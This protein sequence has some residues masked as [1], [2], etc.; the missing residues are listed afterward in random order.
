MEKVWDVVVLG[1]GPA[2]VMSALKLAMSGKKVCMVEQGPQRLGG[3]CLHEGCMATKS[4]LKTAEVYQTIKQAEEYGIEATA[5]PLDLHCTVM[6]KNDHLKTLNNRLQQMALQSGLHI[7]PGHGSFVS[8]TRIAVDGPDG[9]VELQAEKIVIA[10]G[11]R[12]R[13]LDEIP[14]DGALIL[15]S[16]QMLQQTRLPERLLIIGGG[17]IG[18]EFASMFQAFGSDV[19]LIESAEHL[20]PREDRDTGETLQTCLEQ[21]DIRVL[22]GK[23]I[24]RV[25]KTDTQVELVLQGND[26]PLVADQMLVA[27]GRKP[28]TDWLDLAAAEI[29]CDGETI[30]VNDQLQT[31]QP[32]IYAAGDVINTMMLAHSAMLESDIVAANLLGNNKT[33]NTATIPRVVYSFPQVAAVGLTERELPEDSYRALFQPFGESAKA[34][35]DQR[36]EGH[37]KL[38]VDNDSNTICGATIIGEHA[39]ELIHELALTISQDISLGVLKEVVHAHPTLAESIWDLARHQG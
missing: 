10:T 19:T 30:C 26:Q 17:A 18:C 4:M 38:L 3:T 31:S 16:N 22:T 15:N 6:R 8:P 37:I 5:A 34:L 33:L 14:I 13:E 23:T 32:H 7:Q 28:N 9:H 12:P 35:V 39:T 11:S 27:V 29:D 36:L 24:V 21:R 25:N 1:G 20:L 2:G